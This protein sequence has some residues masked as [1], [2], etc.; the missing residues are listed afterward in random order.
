MGAKARKTPCATA[1]GA[2]F[3]SMAALQRTRF[4]PS[5]SN[6]VPASWILAAGR[7]RC[8]NRSI[9]EE[10]RAVR[11]RAGLFDVSHMGEV[12]VTGPDAARFLDHLVTNDVAKLFPGR[13][14]Y[15]TMCQP[16]G[17][18]VDDLL[19]YCRGAADYLL[20]INARQHRQG[21]GLDPRTG[22]RLQL[23]DHRL[24]GGVRV[25]GDP[26]ARRGV[27]LADAHA[28]RTR[29]AEVLSLCRGVVG[30]AG[31]SWPGPATPGRTVF[32]LFCRP[33]DA[34]ALATAL[35]EAGRPHGLEP[36]GLGARDSLRLEAGIR[37]MDTK[38]RPRSRPCRRGSAGS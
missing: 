15:T 1:C 13:V 12:A 27:D 6:S 29:G 9:L 30:G 11:Q 36:A 23:P 3:P 25:A 5:T 21:C 35:L 20:C 22:Q 37:F 33:E 31:C 18:V 4:S 34:A 16:D 32:E 38:S 19:I 10:H 28:G 14:L 7:C 17:G 2:A 8:S 26:G 24:F